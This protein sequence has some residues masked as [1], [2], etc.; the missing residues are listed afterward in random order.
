[1]RGT[2]PRGRM[3]MWANYTWVIVAAAGIAATIILT[4]MVG[5]MLL[6][7]EREPT[8][9]S[10]SDEFTLAV[11]LTGFAGVVVVALSVVAMSVLTEAEN[12]RLL[13]ESLH[14]KY[15]VTGMIPD[16][17]PGTNVVTKPEITLLVDGVS[18]RCQLAIPSS[19]P[20]EVEASCV[21]PNRAD[22]LVPLNELVG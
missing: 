7:T 6:E 16:R 18:Y 2:N 5:S 9:Y 19:G 20:G 10:F 17:F 22:S 21:T 8:S 4:A 15:G 14:T 11:P 13:S 12:S 3:T 1:M